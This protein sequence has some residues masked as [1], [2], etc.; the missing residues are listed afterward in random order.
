MYLV[1]T[2][3]LSELRRRDRAASVVQWFSAVQSVDL[4]ISVI[5]LLELER[6]VLRI[7]RRDG[8]QSEILSR[9]INDFVIR[10]FDDRILPVDAATVRC[11]AGLHVPDPRP[12][13]DA[14]IAATAMVCQL[15]IVTRNVRD[16]E[17]MGVATLNPWNG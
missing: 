14:L 12:E 16:F 8:R 11:C 15:T 3:V 6:G 4:F 1:D 10:G 9:W 2:N 5:S 17:P 7:A 13:H